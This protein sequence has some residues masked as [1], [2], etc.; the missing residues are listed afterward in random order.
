[1]R[2]NIY[3]LF[4]EKINSCAEG[5]Y[6]VTNGPASEIQSNYEN[7]RTDAWSQIEDLGITKRIVSTC[8]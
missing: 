8:T 6:N 3:Y 5:K 4:L 1:M 2:L 7:K